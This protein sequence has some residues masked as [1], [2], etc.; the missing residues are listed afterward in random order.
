MFHNMIYNLN[1]STSTTRQVS[2]VQTIFITISKDNITI[3]WLHHKFVFSI[4]KCEINQSYV[5]SK[6]SSY[7]YIYR[8]SYHCFQCKYFVLTLIICPVCVTNLYI[9]MFCC[10][11]AGWQPRWFVLNNGVLSYY[12]SQEDVNNGCKGSVK[13]SVCDVVGKT[14]AYLQINY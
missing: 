12:K 9:S 1:C 6:F 2:H 14:G 7:M 13:M 10:H 5:I 11:F 4:R 3:A 8:F